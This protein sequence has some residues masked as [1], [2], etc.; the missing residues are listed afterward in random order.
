MAAPSSCP[1][2]ER[3]RRLLH[4]TPPAPDQTEL[5]AHLDHC[6]LCQ[7]ALEELAAVDPALLSAANSLQRTFHPPEAPLRRLLADLEQDSVLAAL[8]TL[9]SSAA[10]VRSFLRPVEEGDALGQLDQYRVTELLG[11]GG[12]GLVLKAFDP[13][14]KRWVAIKVLS[15][16]LAGDRLARQRFARE[17]Q[18]AAAVRHEH[19]TTIHAVSEINGLPFLVMEYVAGG[20]VQDY[21]D[22]HG[23]PDWREIARLGVEIATGLAAAH[24]RG[25]VHRDIKPSNILLH[26][27]GPHAE[28]GV[29]KI[30]DFGVARVADEVRLT[31]TGIVPGTP[32]YMAPEQA[33]C[34]PLDHRAD[35]FSLGSVLYAL[36]TGHEPFAGGTPM[37]VLR[38]VCE[39]T[40]RPIRELNPAIP[41]WLA[42]T[43]ERLHAKRPAD[44]FASAAE[45]ADLLRYNREHPDQPRPVPLPARG[46]RP[47]RGTRRLI[48]GVVVAALLLA[49]GL[50]LTEAIGGANRLGGGT[51][52]D[53]SENRV[54]LRATLSGHAGPVWSMAFAPDG[55]T[56]ATGSDDATLRLWNTRT[57]LETAKLPE[58]SSAVFALA[59]AH[60]GTFLV[61]GDGDGTLRLWDVATREV[62]GVLA[63][64]GGNV[65]RVAIS[66]DDNTVAV[67]G[68]AQG[69]ALWDVAG[70]TIR[71]TLAGH[72]G[73]ILALA[74][75]PDGSTLTTGDATGDIRFW[76]PAT[77][78][79]RARFPGD[80]LGV[81]ALAFTPDGQT[82]ASA[83]TGDKVVKQ[84]NVA[85]HELIASLSGYENGI[86]NL[87]VAPDGRLLATGSR[88]GSV[89][90]WDLSTTRALATWHAHQG[91]VLAVAFH[92]KG[93]T[94]ATAGEDRLGKLWD[95]TQLRTAR[96]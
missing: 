59:F 18:A 83:G 57:G 71:Q 96:P 30:S 41:A 5:I 85:S 61:S 9:P 40:P 1:P 69:V 82:L 48:V 29:A 8:Q 64:Q 65:R 90:I 39:A 95:L 50:L 89:K 91:S 92:P 55:E 44:R 4:G 37:A 66:P 17:A 42:A 53:V 56:L 93:H 33:L 72:H 22:R 23:P 60:N 87:A 80:P 36:C 21:L 32:M 67:G 3:L 75:A 73:T 2:T 68:S 35:L 6:A 43:V 88:D 26:T 74:F 79:E 63:H 25:L 34:E 28:L 19:V 20:S 31:Q 70:R 54:P 84:W 47:R 45:L 11:Q 15:P 52:A 51:S 7:R 94:L 24:G 16:S 86:Q 13:P 14:L 38:Q 10:W 12:M 76:D 27:E 58:H 62:R 77:G 49:G 78:E 46:R 81:R